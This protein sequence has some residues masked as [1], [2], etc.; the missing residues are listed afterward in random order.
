MLESGLIFNRLAVILIDPN[1]DERSGSCFV[2]RTMKD[3]SMPKIKAKL[4]SHDKVGV[5]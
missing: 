1:K 3:V 2:E 5:Y 4:T